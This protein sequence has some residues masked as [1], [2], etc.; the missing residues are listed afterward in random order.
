MKKEHTYIP[1]GIEV[2]DPGDGNKVIVNVL[3]D[4]EIIMIVLS[5]TAARAVAE[6]LIA[7]GLV[8]AKDLPAPGYL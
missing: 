5:D 2:L 1:D 3:G 8:L 4:D 7:K 6:K